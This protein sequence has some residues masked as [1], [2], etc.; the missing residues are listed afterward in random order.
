MI[1]KRAV[2]ILALLV[3]IVLILILI[4]SPT[5]PAGPPITPNDRFFTVSFNGTPEVNI[6]AYN[7]TVFGQV[8][9]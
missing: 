4:P 5:P 3:T 9:R 2:G 6:S 7:L 1:W 8:D